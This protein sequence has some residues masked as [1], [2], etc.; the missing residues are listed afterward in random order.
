[1][2]WVTGT[3]EAFSFLPPPQGTDIASS[4]TVTSVTFK[5]TTKHSTSTL[6][7]GAEAVFSP[8]LQWCVLTTH[9]PT[10]TAA[11]LTL[12]L[13]TIDNYLQCNLCLFVIVLS[14]LLINQP[15]TLHC[16]MFNTVQ[17]L[18]CQHNASL[19][20]CGNTSSIMNNYLDITLYSK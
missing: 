19:Y 5:H 15:N 10:Q 11:S 6:H 12:Q 3:V 20:S 2:Q 1:M 9:T 16:L 8:G 17:H 13:F 7:R 14:S 4:F 18:I